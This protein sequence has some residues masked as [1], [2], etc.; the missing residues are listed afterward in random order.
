MN[1]NLYPSPYEL[2][3]VLSSYTKRAFVDLFARE[4][5]VFFL[6]AKHEEIARDLSY[7]L[8]EESEIETLRAFAYQAVAKHTLSGFTVKSSDQF[9]S[10]ER[11]YDNIR[12]KGELASKGYSLG[13]LCKE[14]RQGQ[15]PTYKGRIEY[16]KK[17]PGRIEFLE[18]ETGYAEFSFFETATGEWQVEV[19]GSKSADGKEV[20]RLF[21]GSIGKTESISNIY[22]DALK[23]KDTIAFFD[24]LATSGL[25]ADWRFLDIKYLAF[26]RGNIVE[27]EDD[28]DQ[29]AGMEELTG[30]RQ[31]ILEGRD[32]RNDP[33]VAQY[34]QGGCIFTAMT[35]EI[36]NKTS[37]EI[38]QL[39]AEFKGHPKIFEVSITDYALRKGL[40]AKKEAA[41]ISSNRRK[42]LTSLFWN[43]AKTVFESLI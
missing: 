21:L 4:R 32:L 1:K 43:N 26:K 18:E 36:E 40:E 17:K 31:A 30:I 39:R 29:E 38:I 6:N 15:K 25:G 41:T 42:E 5:C 14:D 24:E 20:Q 2:Q 34:E 23:Q 33:F 10:L 19:D 27:D 37:S 9:F 28:E 16:K 12:E 8:Y 7:F 3:E 22:I 11:L 13:A 35:Y